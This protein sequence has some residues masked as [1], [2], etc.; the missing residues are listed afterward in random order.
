M[1]QF[2]KYAGEIIAAAASSP[3]G[4]LA[5]IVLVVGVL[6]Y[7]LFRNASENA[8]IIIF[9]LVLISGAAFGAVVLDKSFTKSEEMARNAAVDTLA[10]SK[11]IASTKSA[12]E[13][14]KGTKTPKAAANPQVP[15]E[16]PPPKAESPTPA[17]VPPREDWTDAQWEEAR[18]NIRWIF[19]DSGAK[20]TYDAARTR[21][22]SKYAAVLAA[23]GH[24][25]NAQ[26]SIAA[27]GEVRAEKFVASLGH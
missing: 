3:W 15:A 14:T 23:Q 13:S 2:F 24:N 4:I 8:R 1:E 22:L 26:R 27:Y 5:L 20:R 11:T 18:V 16:A 9:V 12:T 6:A 10:V 19:Q 7:L 17:P 21:G 25:A